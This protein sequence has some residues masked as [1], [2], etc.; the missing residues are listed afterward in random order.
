[1]DAVHAGVLALALC[2]LLFNW[3]IG[4][5]ET[6][7]KVILTVVYLLTWALI[8][9]GWWAV[10]ATQAILAIVLGIMTF[11]LDWMMR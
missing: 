1:M 7:T 8:F 3:Q 10:T 5:Q 9:I 4:E 2:L 6:K 11:G